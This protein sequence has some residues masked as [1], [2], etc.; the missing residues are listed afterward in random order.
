[1][2]AQ[3]PIW[4]PGQLVRNASTAPVTTSQT[5]YDLWWRDNPSMHSLFF[6]F[7]FLL[8]S[9]DVDCNRDLAT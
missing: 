4:N 8:F 2:H 7:L 5:W 9:F 3:L 1:M 6:F